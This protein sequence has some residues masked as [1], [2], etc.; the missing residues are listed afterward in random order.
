MYFFSAAPAEFGKKHDA[1]AEPEHPSN[2]SASGAD[3]V[4]PSAPKLVSDALD[5][6]V[7]PAPEAIEDA[8]A[9]VDSPS[10]S[11]VLYDVVD[12]AEPQESTTFFDELEEDMKLECAKYGAVDHVREPND[13]LSRCLSQ[14][15]C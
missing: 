11:I 4:V 15:P 8:S 12:P 13:R 1:I 5:A 10:K 6:A 9:R 14:Y 7:D 3:A 2:S